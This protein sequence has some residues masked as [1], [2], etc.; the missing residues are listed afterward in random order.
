MTTHFDPNAAHAVYAPSSAHRWTV[1]TASA[2]AIGRLG[3]QEEGEAA[4]EGTRAH[5]EIER[6]LSPT[7]EVRGV[8]GM[9]TF[10]VDPDH[11]AAYGVAMVLDYV[12]QLPAGRLWIEQRVILTGQIW[13]R[14]DVAHWHEES[15][16]LTIVDY[17]NGFVGVDVEDNEQLQI[18]AAASIY[19]H[20]LP[21][22]NVRLVVV[23]PNDFRPVPRVKQHVMTAE[24]LLEFASRAAAI[25]GGPKVFKAGEHCRYCPLFGRC[26]AT[27]DLLAHL[28]VAMQHTPEDVPLATRATFLTLRKPL[29][30]W[31]KN[32][33][34]AWLKDALATGPAPGMKLVT[35]ATR[36]DWKDPAAARAAV[37]AQFGVDA[38]DPPTPAQAEKLGMDKAEVAALADTP[39]GGPALAFESD[40]RKS[41]VVKS[42]E[43]MFAGVTNGAL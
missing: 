2:E 34:K 31:F 30:D 12:R 18:Y 42:I 14:C 11:P 4:A 35:T 27:R 21:A 13:G 10:D 8:D 39:E 36:R 7:C 22:Q 17:K 3:E 32:A 28:A 26:E 38:L 23:Q 43:S 40:K 1:C 9:V 33:D 15:K 25:P 6:C 41:F 20:K 37:V 5:D 24:A 19:T 16:T 29:E